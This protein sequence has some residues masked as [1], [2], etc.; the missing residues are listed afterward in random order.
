MGKECDLDFLNTLSY[1][2][3]LIEKLKYFT[4]KKYRNKVIFCNIHPL[5]QYQR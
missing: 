3:V 4:A 2:N 1:L 5:Q